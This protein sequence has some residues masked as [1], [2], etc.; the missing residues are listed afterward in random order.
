MKVTPDAELPL[1]QRFP[2]LALR[3]RREP[4]CGLPTPVTRAPGLERAVDCGPLWIKS[5]G[6]SAQPYGGSKPRKL[7]WIL[8]RIRARGIRRIVT[9]GGLGTN[10]GLATALYARQLGVACELILVPQPL[11]ERVRLRI[12]QLVASGATIHAC[13]SAL[14]GVARGARCLLRPPRAVLIPTGGSS[15]LGA[16]GLVNAGLELA[17][18]VDAGVLPEPARLYVALGSGGTA[19]GLAAG[20]SLAGLRTRVVAIC[21][22]DFFAPGPRRLAYKARRALRLVTREA[23]ARRAGATLRLEV[24]RRFL[25]AG[26][27]SPTAEGERA[28]ELAGD[29]TGLR[30]EPTYTSKALAAL[31]ARERGVRDPLLFWNTHASSEPDLA[32]PDWRALPG[33]LQR[34]FREPAAP[35]EPCSTSACA[36]P[37][38]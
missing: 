34:F 29:L 5:D 9:S 38:P 2:D 26:Y 31:F 8:G 22:S 7:E 37:D 36:Q 27:G 19:A 17:A 18:Q 23:S 25:G 4:L 16:L 1:V 15:A 12:L 28:G 21:V 10:H 3:L 14:A 13:S 20:L 24:D 32:L 6:A 33:A 35:D 30:L 11:D